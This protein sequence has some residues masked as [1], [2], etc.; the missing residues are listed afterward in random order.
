MLLLPVFAAPGKDSPEFNLTLLIL[1]CCLN[2]KDHMM[3]EEPSLNTLTHL[4]STQIQ[5]TLKS[6]YSYYIMSSPLASNVHL[7]HYKQY[8]RILC[9]AFFGAMVPTE[10]TDSV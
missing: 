2:F 3:K 9:N 7:S 8:L 1:V 5:F 6:V 10:L 4:S